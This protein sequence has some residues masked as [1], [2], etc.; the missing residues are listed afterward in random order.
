VSIHPVVGPEVLTGS[1][2]LKAGTAQKLVLDMLTTGTMV[3][4]GYVYANR[5]IALRPTNSKLRDRA[6]RI[7]TDITGATNEA[8]AAAL[9]QAGW[10]VPTAIVMLEGGLSAEAANAR[11]DAVGSYAEAIQEQR[12]TKATGASHHAEAGH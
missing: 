10:A 9:D 8:A 1:S 4:L 2:R 12:A 6:H 5:M 3:R 11:I 7:V